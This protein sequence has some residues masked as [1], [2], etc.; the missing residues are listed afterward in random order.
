MSHL[1][2]WSSCHP[3]HPALAGCPWLQGP[4]NPKVG[5]SLWVQLEDTCPAPSKALVQNEDS[6]HVPMWG[7]GRENQPGEIQQTKVLCWRKNQ[8]P[9][10]KWGTSNNPGKKVLF[11]S[12]EEETAWAPALEL[13]HW[14]PLRCLSQAEEQQEWAEAVRMGTSGRRL[15]LF[16]RTS[17]ERTQNTF[18][19][20]HVENYLKPPTLHTH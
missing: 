19:L 16:V 7:T 17:W 5:S 12:N 6:H 2:P 13:W 8:L 10:A 15:M 18:A 20:L 11:G 4:G 3:P 14:S 1:S 9:K